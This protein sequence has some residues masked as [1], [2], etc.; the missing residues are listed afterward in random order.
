M[1]AP[2]RFV[3]DESDF[4]V[5][6]A[7]HDRRITATTV[8]KASTPSGF[9]HVV[10]TWGNQVDDNPF[11]AFGRKWE[12]FIAR[13]VQSQTGILHSMWLIESESD[14]AFAATP[15]GLSLDHTM[16]AEIKTSGKPLDKI[17]AQYRR[18]IQW[19]MFVTGAEKC[20]FAW[21][22]RGDNFQPAEMEPHLQWVDRDEKEIKRLIGV[23]EKLK[24]KLWLA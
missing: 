17:P 20:A 9:E 21:F 4:S 19:Q 5:W 11:M 2:G 14:P 12:P 16:T 24:E 18:Q 1:I 13:W 3:C 10:G 23:A 6:L 7:E 8:A 22:L 15:D